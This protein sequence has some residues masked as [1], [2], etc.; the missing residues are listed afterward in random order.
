[1]RKA[2]AAKHGLVLSALVV[3]LLTGF[4]PS[5]RQGPNPVIFVHG[6]SGSG[7]QFESQ[8]MRFTSNGYPPGH[9]AV[10]EYDSSLPFPA[11]LPPVLEAIDARIAELKAATGARQVDLLGHS[12]GTSVCQA[13]LA[14]A[15]RAANVAHYVNID[16]QPA[17][18]PPGGVPTLALWAGA[19]DRPVQG[20]IVGATNVT[21]PNQE[22][23]EVATSEESFFEIYR[24]FRGRAPFTTRILPQLL[25]RISGRV[26]NFPANTGLE[27][28]TLEI[29]RVDGRTGERRGRKPRATFT[30]GPDGSFG[31]VW[32][33]IGT[34]HEFAVMQAGRR[35]Y[36][37]YYE[38]FLRSDDLVRLNVAPLL[39]PFIPAD[40]DSASVSVVRYKEF[41]G[42]RGAENDVLSIDGTDV[43]NPT[44][45]PSG[46]V[47]A[48]SVAFFAFDSNS[49]GVSNLLSVPFPMSTLPFLTGADLFIPTDAPRTVRVETVPRGD[50]DEARIVNVPNL[51]SSEHA[52]V[53]QLRDFE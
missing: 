21:I 9:V 11:S 53:I 25:P 24:F 20:Q 42:D 18:A 35:I 1:M 10:V 26:V 5:R 34:H 41:W 23:V 47:G 32:T 44:T 17:A 27:G 51:P 15:E 38:R 48:A 40:P 33:L 4:V 22:H 49:D 30:I 31:P 37:A 13:Y 29:W 19:V 12:R 45:A 2:F 43:I 46:A 36:H 3:L 8:A 7:A 6:G 28:A 39:E 14:T 52:I 16:G 50:F